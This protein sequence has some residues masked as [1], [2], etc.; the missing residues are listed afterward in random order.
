MK[1]LIMV[2]LRHVVGR[3]NR[4]ETEMYGRTRYCSTKNTSRA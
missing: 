1:K 3:T 2:F 4:D